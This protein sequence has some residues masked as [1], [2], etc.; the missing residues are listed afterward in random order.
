MDISKDGALRLLEQMCADSA[1]DFERGVEAYLDAVS[2]EKRALTTF[3]KSC[4]QLVRARNRKYNAL[5]IVI[6]EYAF[7][8]DKEV[9]KPE[10][11]GKEVVVQL[12]VNIIE[13]LDDEKY[14]E[15]AEL[16]NEEEEPEKN[17][18]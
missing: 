13:H 12:L 2:A 10:L 15:I 7:L 8:T 16:F 1:E 18:L 5:K 14:L 9:V 17:D 4:T 11:N 6:P 3:K